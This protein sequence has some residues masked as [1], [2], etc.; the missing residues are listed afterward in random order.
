MTTTPGIQGN[1]VVLKYPTSF[2]GAVF[3]VALWSNRICSLRQR[4]I[5]E[6]IDL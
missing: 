5:F 4:P 1:K 3:D 2:F 6:P